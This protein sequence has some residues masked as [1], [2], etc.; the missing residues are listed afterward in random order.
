MA[1]TCVHRN[2]FDVEEEHGINN[3]DL[4]QENTWRGAFQQIWVYTEEVLNCLNNGKTK[5]KERGE[6]RDVKEGKVKKSHRTREGIL[7]FPTQSVCCVKITA[8]KAQF[9]FSVRYCFGKYLLMLVAL[10][11]LIRTKIRRTHTRPHPNTHKHT[12]AHALAFPKRSLLFTE[13]FSLL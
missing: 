2:I 12:Y 6:Q 7:L 8:G 3:K 11:K 10:L 4:P 5:K 9:I 1:N 13:C